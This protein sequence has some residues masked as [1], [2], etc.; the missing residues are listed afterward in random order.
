MKRGFISALLCLVMAFA[1]LPVTAMAADAHVTKITEENYKGLYLYSN[2]DY[3]DDNAMAFAASN[4]DSYASNLNLYYKWDQS[5]QGNIVVWRR[6]SS[7]S[8][9]TANTWSGTANRHSAALVHEY[10]SVNTPYV[11]GDIATE[12]DFAANADDVTGSMESQAIDVTVTTTLT[13]NAFDRE[14]YTFDG[15]N[16]AADGSGIAVDDGIA[17]N[18]LPDLLSNFGAAAGRGTLTLYAQWTANEYTASF[19][20]NGGTVDAETKTVTY[21]EAVGELP[22]PTRRGYHFDGWYYDGERYDERT[23]Y[24]VADDITLTAQW[25]RSRTSGGTSTTDT[26]VTTNSPKTADPGV[27]VYAALATLALG[28]MAVSVLKKKAI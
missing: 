7:W 9:Y 22:T 8:G 21:G 14:G 11:L 26:T 13:A 10:M 12:I 1:L 3:T 19:D 20:A 4:L 15:W 23:V 24:Q 6:D 25:T 16:T 5:A 28:G 18:T 2:S 27:A 17:M